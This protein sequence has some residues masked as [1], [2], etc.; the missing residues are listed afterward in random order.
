MSI[1]L[2]IQFAEL[3]AK[4]GAPAAVK[5]VHIWSERHPDGVTLEDIEELAN[6]PLP[7][8]LLTDTIDDS[9]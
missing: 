4:Y 9:A 3:V 6:I 8:E 1:K 7:E 5:I 2:I